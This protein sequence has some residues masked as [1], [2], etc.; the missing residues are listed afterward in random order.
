[1][2]YFEALAETMHFGKAAN[3]AN[4][5]QPALSAQIAEMEA[6]LGCQLFERTGRRVR[7]SPQGEA[8]KPR[9]TR[10]LNE[11]RELEAIARR[12]PGVL[13]GRFRLGIIPTVAPYLLPGLLGDLKRRFP[14]LNLEIREAVTGTLI[15][16]TASGSL[17]A[18]LAADPLDHPALESHALFEDRFYLA[19]PSDDPDFITPPVPPESPHLERLLL[20]DEGH[21]LR[22]QALAV[23]G[24]A[25]P[26]NMS[27]YGATSLGTL[28]QMVAHG[29]GITLIP[30]MAVAAESAR[31]DLKIVPFT[32]PQPSRTICLAWRRN[33]L[34][35]KECVL[36]AQVM[37]DG[38]D[39][40]AARDAVMPR[41][42]PVFS[43]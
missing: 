27:N 17:D 36:L 11:M 41:A 28:L 37:Q 34:R 24:E 43:G 25:R 42:E 5:T 1:M 12:G 39:M 9:I 38:R 29:I 31:S 8:L 16:E 10:I 23:C 18:M 30:E 26:V 21:C 4:V 20:L 15:D 6:R 40:A 33:G 3:L 2:T 32:D 13:E 19:A 7:L 22:D 14:R 35:A